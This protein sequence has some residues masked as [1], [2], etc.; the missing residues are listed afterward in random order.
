MRIFFGICVW[1]MALTQQALAD[2]VDPPFE[3]RCEFDTLAS[4]IAPSGSTEFTVD[5]QHMAGLDSISFFNIN[6]ASRSALAEGNNIESG[7]VVV[8]VWP[9]TWTFT[10]YTFVGNIYVTQV[11]VENEPDARRG[12]FRAIRSR[13]WASLGGV[14]GT[15]QYGVCRALS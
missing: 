10:E 6:I 5:V 9:S 1:A 7:R 8:E 11:F 2:L 3:L 13:Q 12:I 15:Q 14:Y 4:A